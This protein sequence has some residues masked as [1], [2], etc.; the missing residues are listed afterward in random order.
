MNRPVDPNLIPF[1]NFQLSS[2]IAASLRQDPAYANGKCATTLVRSQELTL[3][4]V[5]LNQGGELKE[6]QA[7]G[8]AT[9]LVL[10]GEIR[11]CRE[12]QEDLILQTNDCAVFAHEVKHSVQALQESLLLL[13]IGQKSSPAQ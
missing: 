7:P 8:P 2:Q 1:S 12:A 10:E 5:A 6:H 11:F 3:V 9:A 4:L 13:I